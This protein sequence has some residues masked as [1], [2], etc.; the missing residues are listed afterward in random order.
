MV[1]TGLKATRKTMGSP[2][3][4]PPCTPPLW[5]VRVPSPLPRRTNGSLWVLPRRRVPAKPEPMSNPLVAGRLSMAWARRASSLSN[6]GSPKP[7]GTLRQT[8]VRM[9]PVE[10]FASSTSRTRSCMRRAV[11]ASGQRMMF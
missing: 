1:A 3:L 5:L 11:A 10:S 4:I 7:T 8:Q 9:P 6:S 2:L